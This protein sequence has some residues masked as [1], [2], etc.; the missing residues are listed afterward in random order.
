V[1]PSRLGF[2]YYRFPKDPVQW[3]AYDSDA[4]RKNL[5]LTCSTAS[6]IRLKLFEATPSGECHRCDYRDKC[7]PGRKYVAARRVETGGRIDS[8]IFDLEPV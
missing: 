8:S 7:E 6:N 3:I 5:D 4:L 2:I 1:A